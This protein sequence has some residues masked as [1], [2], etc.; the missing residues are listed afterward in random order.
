L[1]A[2]SENEVSVRLDDAGRNQKL[3]SLQEVIKLISDNK[4][5]LIFKTIFLAS[6]DS[7]ENLRTQLKLTKK[8]YYSRISR[9]TKAGLVNR[10]KGRYFVTAFGMVIYDAQRLLG[11]AV[12]NYWKLRAIDSLGAAN[13]NNVPREE[14]AKII[15]L[16]IGNPQIKEI[17]LSTKF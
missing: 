9:L 1:N 3:E 4:S 10:Q 6:G 12:K 17:L 5:L 14:R 16:M 8:Q 15:D 13:D 7:G 11:S 2:N